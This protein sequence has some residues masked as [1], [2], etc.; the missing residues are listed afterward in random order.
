LTTQRCASINLIGKCAK[1][2]NRWKNLR[3][4]SPIDATKSEARVAFFV[5][6]FRRFLRHAL[7]LVPLALS[8]LQI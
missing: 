8:R 5:E 3:K 4:V 6:S 7:V 1:K 2:Y